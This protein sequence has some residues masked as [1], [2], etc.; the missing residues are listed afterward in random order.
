MT[1]GYSVVYL[2]AIRLLG[3][4]VRCGPLV[5]AEELLHGILAA[6]CSTGAIDHAEEILNMCPEELGLQV[7]WWW[8]CGTAKGGE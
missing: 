6:Y 7:P 5:S 8:C 1:T 3:R 2:S 4:T